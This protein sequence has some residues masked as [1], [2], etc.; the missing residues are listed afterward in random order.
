MI[1]QV[2]DDY[3]PESKEIDI[4]DL[5]SSASF[6]IKRFPDA[7]YFGECTKND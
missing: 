7:I 3:I 4:N 1:K 5:R 6:Y 2:L